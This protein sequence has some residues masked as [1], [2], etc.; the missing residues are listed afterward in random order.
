MNSV[1]RTRTAAVE[2]QLT[3]TNPALQAGPGELREQLSSRLIE[4]RTGKI[5]TCGS[6]ALN[7]TGIT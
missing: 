4:T 1:S 5:I 6:L 3:T 2:Q 7:K